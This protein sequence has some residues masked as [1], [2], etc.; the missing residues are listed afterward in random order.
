MP[1]RNGR[2]RNVTRMQISCIYVIPPTASIPTHLHRADECWNPQMTH[3][4]PLSHRRAWNPRERDHPRP[5]AHHYL[6]LWRA[7]KGRWDSHPRR[8]WWTYL[9]GERM[10]MCANHSRAWKKGKRTYCKPAFFTLRYISLRP[11]FPK[12][13]VWV[14]RKWGKKKST[15]VRVGFKK[16]P[17]IQRGLGRKMSSHD[18]K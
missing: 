11:F 7:G 10:C 12:I 4:P 9:G 3:R 13:D 15:P 5:C 18:E 17:N 6:R 8:R 14:K 16:R 1:A 2:G